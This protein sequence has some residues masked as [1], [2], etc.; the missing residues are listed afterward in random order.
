MLTCVFGL[1]DERLFLIDEPHNFLHPSLERV[2]I[3]LF[4]E[5]QHSFVLATHSAQMIN[6]V[7]PNRIISIEK[8]G[9]SKSV[10]V[11]GA[12]KA[13][14]LSHLGFRNSDLLFHDALIFVE[15]A[16]DP[17]LF[18][19]LFEKAGCSTP[20]ALDV[21][22]VELGGTGEFQS[23]D[24][25]QR[26]VIV[27][28]RLLQSFSKTH[29]PHVYLFD[30]D[31]AEYRERLERTKPAGTTITPVFLDV[32]EVENYLLD[33]ASIEIA[34]N[35]ELRSLDLPTT[36]TVEIIQ[37]RLDVLLCPEKLGAA[38]QKKFYPQ[39]WK[40]KPS[41]ALKG[42][43]AL[44]DIYSSFSLT[45]NKRTSGTEIAS[46]IVLSNEAKAEICRLFKSFNF[47]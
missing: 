7:P 38:E 28:E 39:G 6:R 37:K 26:L 18:E 42:S 15:G 25:I 11:K 19:A 27:Q 43:R 46:N 20:K 4:S 31:K 40:D 29:V 9:T 2:L 32:Y 30:G 10:Y 23:F 1:R 3:D 21:G 34:I 13:Q 41:F 5:S 14:V 44:E 33:A 16:S 24:A 35:S 47:I 36:A 8:P 12:D 22:Y 45:Y 17:P